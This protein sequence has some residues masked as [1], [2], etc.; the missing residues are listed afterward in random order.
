MYHIISTSGLIV[1]R[2]ED[3]V[4]ISSISR[5]ILGYAEG[6][7]SRELDIQKL[8]VRGVLPGY[9]TGGIAGY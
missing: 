3:A 7:I 6:L 8:V 9:E 1:S 2:G 4:G 5:T